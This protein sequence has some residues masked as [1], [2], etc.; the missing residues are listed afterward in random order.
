MNVNFSR[1]LKG[2]KTFIIKIII[3]IKRVYIKYINCSNYYYYIHLLYYI[4][5]NAQYSKL[6]LQIF[7][8]LNNEF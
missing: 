5:S 6:F 3:V 4:G 2:S 1:K 8:L 7:S